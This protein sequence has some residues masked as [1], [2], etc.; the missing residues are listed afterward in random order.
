MSVDEVYKEET[1]FYEKFD[2]NWKRYLSIYK[3]KNIHNQKTAWE[4]ANTEG[5]MNSH[6]VF[7]NDSDINDNFLN[8][9]LNFF[10]YQAIIYDFDWQYYIN[11]N[12]LPEYVNNEE[13][14][15]I[16][17]NIYGLQKGLKYKYQNNNEKMKSNENLNG[18]KKILVI[19]EMEKA[20]ENSAIRRIARLKIEE[21]EK[22]T[23]NDKKKERDNIEMKIKQKINNEKC[24]DKNKDKENILKIL[25][26]SFNEIRNR[27]NK[28]K[29][30]LNNIKE[31][32]VKLKNEVISE[33]IETINKMG[34]FDKNIVIGGDD[35]IDE[36]NK[37]NN[38]NITKE[39]EE[40]IQNMVNDLH[41]NIKLIKCQ[42][43]KLEE[44]LDT[45]VDCLHKLNKFNN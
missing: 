8:F 40:E 17:W 23:R 38:I 45:S 43:D 20:R 34:Y 13:S 31:L 15:L 16:H 14:A 12:L 26:I 44:E 10:N 6:I 22:K 18:N 19:D 30:Q 36:L 39:L 5:I 24:K 25:E 1:F 37:I 7:P 33:R 35:N 28:E 11:N 41:E 29:E 9:K 2:N 3:I 21:A 32:E 4:Y 42:K 27:K